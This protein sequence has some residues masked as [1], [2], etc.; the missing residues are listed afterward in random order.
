MVL[1]GEHTLSAEWP[2]PVTPQEARLSAPLPWARHRVAGSEQPLGDASALA[3]RVLTEGD[4]AV[5]PHLTHGRR[6]TNSV[7]CK[8]EALPIISSEPTHVS[9]NRPHRGN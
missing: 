2:P 5:A 4:S 6:S 9:Q 1:A 3:I 7:L 8:W